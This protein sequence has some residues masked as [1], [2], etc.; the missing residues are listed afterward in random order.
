MKMS[1]TKEFAVAI[2]TELSEIY[3]KVW[4]I[5]NSID[6]DRTSLKWYTKQN[7]TYDGAAVRIKAKIAE[8][9]ES[10]L[11]L[12]ARRT[13]LNR[14]HSVDLWSRAYLVVSSDGHV[15]SSMQCSTCY[16]QTYFRWLVQYSND[17]ESTIVEDA[18]ELACT[19]C[20]PSAP[21]ETLN[22]PTRIVIKEK[23]AKEKARVERQ[24]KSDAKKAKARVD[25]PT[26]SGEPL[27]IP[28]GRTY[29]GYDQFDEFKTERSATSEWLRNQYNINHGWGTP[30]YD[31]TVNTAIAQALAGKHGVSIEEQVAT[32][33]A[34]LAKRR[35]G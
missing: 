22:R 10:L 21:A 33:E 27:R 3:E 23:V 19:V 9:Y 30:D 4:K 16:P 1:V 14:I 24:V 34:K 17:A 8:A 28:N 18:G 11:P 35:D 2:D 5:N 31:K 6:L 7:G 26:V 15:H 29:N 32:L 12:V 13:E 20:Y 25:A